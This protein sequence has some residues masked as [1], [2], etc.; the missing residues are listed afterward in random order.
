MG[1]LVALAVASLP[2]VPE[3]ELQ[4][5]YAHGTDLQLDAGAPCYGLRVGVDPVTTFALVG[6]L[7]FRLR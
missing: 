7:I 3:V 6:G 2:L 4:L 1:S 5:G